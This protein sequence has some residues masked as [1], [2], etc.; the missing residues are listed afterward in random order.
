MS[1]TSPKDQS[2]LVHNATP[3]PPRQRKPGE[4][5]FE[6]YRESDHSRWLC[7]LR[8][9]GGYGVEAQFYQ[10]EEFVYGRR[11]DRRL[12]PSRPSRELAIAVSGTSAPASRGPSSLRLPGGYGAQQNDGAGASICLPSS[13]GCHA[14][15]SRAAV[16]AE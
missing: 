10:N 16:I 4:L 13:R 12:A 15:R 5:L 1:D 8:D 2:R 3:T 7:E 14:T 6:L 9:H 11:F